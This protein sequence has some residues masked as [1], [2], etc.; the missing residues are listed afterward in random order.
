MSKPSQW[1]WR[2][3]AFLILFLFFPQME[4]FILGSGDAPRHQMHSWEGD[5]I[6]WASFL[7]SAFSLFCSGPWLIFPRNPTG[8]RFGSAFSCLA[9]VWIVSL[10]SVWFCCWGWS[11][12]WGCCWPRG[13]R[14]K[15][16]EVLSV[17][18]SL[19]QSVSSMNHNLP[20]AHLL[21]C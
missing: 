21:L 6:P 3:V 2:L 10:F 7:T 1:Y 12:G 18:W 15:R 8:I 4:A 13:R 9:L 17:V 14:G 19:T 11:W 5:C 20:G 16:R